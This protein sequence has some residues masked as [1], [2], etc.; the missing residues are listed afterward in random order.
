MSV[1]D[2]SKLL[3]ASVR[4]V[5][6]FALTGAFIYAIVVGLPVEAV[7]ALAG[8]MGISIGFYFRERAQVTPPS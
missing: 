7:A 3:S 6:C 4:P 1:H 8:P 5:I 2:L